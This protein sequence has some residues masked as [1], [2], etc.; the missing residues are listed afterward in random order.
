MF[1]LNTWTYS[2]LK[3]EPVA[4]LWGPYLAR[5]KLAVLD[6]D[7]GAGKTFLALDLAARLSRGGPLPDGKTLARPHTT[8]LLIADDVPADTTRPRLEAAGADLG[9]I[10]AAYPTA[11]GFRLPDH[12]HALEDAVRRH[13]ADLVVIDPL[14][15][16][17][18]DAATGDYLAARKALVPLVVAA[19]T[20]GCAILLV[21]HLTKAGTP[22]SIYRGVGSI[23]VAG[24]VGTGLLVA[25]HPDDPE[26][27][28]LTQTKNK[29]GPPAP[30]LGFRLRPDDRGRAAVEWAGPVDLSADELCAAP[31]VPPG[32]RPRERA[33]E[34]LQA[35]LANG[36]RKASELITSAAT[37]G[38][39]LRTLERAKKDLGVKCRQVRTDETSEWVWSDRPA[40]P[41]PDDPVTEVRT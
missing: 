24:T 28:V 5:G 17:V 2:E 37:A 7:P 41:D 33:V 34:W 11:P 22:R 12:V 26:L 40:D 29:V 38:I 13:R 15:G 36:T 9:R 18:P 6:G 35:S 14:A 32:K 3:S 20:L 19:D 30:S 39:P 1:P 21:R 27:R 16:I 10:I 8:L 4:W 31:P 23:G 25:R